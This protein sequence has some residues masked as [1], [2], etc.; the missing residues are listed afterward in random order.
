MGFRRD[1]ELLEQFN[2]SSLKPS[3]NGSHH[4]FGI[5]PALTNM[6]LALP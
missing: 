5:L 3:G 2:K 1:G 6:P 4:A